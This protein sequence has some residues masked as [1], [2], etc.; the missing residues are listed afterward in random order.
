MQHLVAMVDP[1]RSLEVWPSAQR[2]VIAEAPFAF[3]AEVP[4]KAVA[5]QL[6][7]TL[8]LLPAAAAQAMPLLLRTLQSQQAADSC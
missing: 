5:V 3:P 8:A 2:L 1:S 6:G 7:S 4:L